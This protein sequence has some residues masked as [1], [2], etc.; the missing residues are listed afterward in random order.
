MHV[1]YNLLWN[2]IPENA[3]VALQESN[4]VF[5]ELKL[6]DSETRQALQK[7]SYLPQ[8]VTVHDVLTRNTSQRIQN[9]FNTIKNIFP[10]W[11]AGDNGVTLAHLHQSS[12]QFS[13]ITRDWY[14]KRPIW[15]LFMLS[16]F[17]KEA[18]EQRY[19]PIL[20]QFLET[21]SEGVGKRVEAIETVHDQCRPLNRLNNSD[22]STKCIR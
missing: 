5:L 19:K 4:R 12:V 22:V 16:S 8:N 10:K 20:D 21:G 18:I 13:A 14:L 6:T 2:D 17:T 9:Y 1:P 11:T 15:L 7:C 3:K